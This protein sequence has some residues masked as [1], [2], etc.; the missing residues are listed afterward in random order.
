M[1]ID[2]HTSIPAST[3]GLSPAL[4]CWN[5]ST[6]KLLFFCRP[7][8]RLVEAQPHSVPLG[9]LAKKKCRGRAINI[10]FCGSKGLILDLHC[11]LTHLNAAGKKARELKG[12]W[13]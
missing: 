5:S 1:H 6:N 13:M 10:S 12:S 2:I 8:H 11:G 4:R 3:Q 9:S 7:A